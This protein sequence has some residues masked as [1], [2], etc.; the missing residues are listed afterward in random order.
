MIEVA[1][2]FILGLIWLAAASY[3]DLKVTEVPNWLSFSLIIFAL[4]F[5][6]FYS[7]FSESATG[8]NF[9]YQGLIG[10]GIFFVLGNLFYYSRVFAGG[11][12]KLM[13]AMGTVLP[14]SESFSINLRVFVLFLGCFLFFGVVYGFIWSI[15]YMVKNFSGFKKCF[16]KQFNKNKKIVFSFMILGI[17]LILL[18]FV[19]ESFFI[20]G[21]FVFS[22]PYFFIYAK[23]IEDAAMIVRVS[24]R[25]LVEGDWLYKDVKIGREIIKSNWEGVSKRDIK[26]L[27][28]LRKVWIR[29]GIP[30]VP[31]FLFAFLGI[32]YLWLRGL[33]NFVF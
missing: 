2:L 16:S 28:K 26:K 13:I 33:I 22:F 24:T 30:F 17:F 14:F 32:I 25:N 19:S 1:F 10:L 18:G 5:R 3:Q 4:G 9:F 15:F 29:R 21:I 11:D 31:V 27:Q 20:F 7:L 6:F 12:A 23:S 8:F